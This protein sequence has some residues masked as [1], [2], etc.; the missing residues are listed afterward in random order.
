[1]NKSHADEIQFNSDNDFSPRGIRYA[2][3]CSENG[4]KFATRSAVSNTKLKQKK[5]EVTRAELKS[6]TTNDDRKKFDYVA[7]SHSG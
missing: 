2:K 6:T 1:M 4:K 3:A 5:E 7:K